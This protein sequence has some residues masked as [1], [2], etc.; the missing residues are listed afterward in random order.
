MYG[1]KVEEPG[2]GPEPEPERPPRR[3]Q[4]QGGTRT[5]T[6]LREFYGIVA[7]TEAVD[8]ELAELDKQIQAFD[9]TRARWTAVP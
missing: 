5:E 1:R 9:E 2:P 3:Q 8:S 6:A 4:Q 7:V